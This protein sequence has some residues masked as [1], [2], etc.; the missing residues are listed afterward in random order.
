MRS[1]TAPAASWIERDDRYLV[2]EIPHDVERVAVQHDAIAARDGVSAEIDLGRGSC[3]RVD[4]IEHA[5]GAVDGDQLPSVR[6]GGDSIE[7]R[8]GHQ[9]EVTRQRDRMSR[10]GRPAAGVERDR[11]D[12]G[13]H[14]VSDVDRIV[15]DGKIVQKRARK[16]A[17]DIDGGNLFAATQ[18]RR[19]S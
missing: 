16:R 1:V 7:I 18:T 14:R 2:Q 13:G 15:R 8:P 9:R 12:H 6:S 19:H 3:A 5:E 11:P 10:A 17:G 4:P